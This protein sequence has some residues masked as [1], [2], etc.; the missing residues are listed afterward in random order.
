MWTIREHPKFWAAIHVVV[1]VG[2]TSPPPLGKLF[3]DLVSQSKT[4]RS[5]EPQGELIGLGWLACRAEHRV[6]H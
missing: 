1:V 2:M 3:L 5:Q 6:S 4:V